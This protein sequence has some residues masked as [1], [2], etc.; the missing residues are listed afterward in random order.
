METLQGIIT[1]IIF[2]NNENGFTV[3]IMKCKDDSDK[4]GYKYHTCTGIIGN[5]YKGITVNLIGN[6]TTNNYGEQFKFE[7][8]ET[9]E[10]TFE[11]GIIGYLSCG[12]IDEVDYITAKKIYEKFKEDTIKILDR[13]PELLMEIKGIGKV[14]C[15]AIINSW[16]E[17]RINLKIHMLLQK[18]GISNNIIEKLK[19][20]CTN[21][22]NLKQL[23]INDNYDLISPYD[24][25]DSDN[26]LITFDIIERILQIVSPETFNEL[27]FSFKR[28]DCATY[29][30]LK[31]DNYNTGNICN[32]YDSVLKII[33]QKLNI[34]I[35]L[36][37]KRYQES[38]KDISDQSFLHTILETKIVSQVKPSNKGYF[39]C[40]NDYYNE[41][42]IAD[43]LYERMKFYKDHM[44]YNE[45]IVNKLVDK[46]E[47]ENNICYNESQRLAIVTAISNPVTIITGGPG[48]GKTT[49]IKA[50]KDILTCNNFQST[51]IKGQSVLLLAPTGKAVKR[52]RDATEHSA[53]TI[54]MVSLCQH[55]KFESAECIII[56]EASMIDNSLMALLC[57]RLYDATT[58]I[59]FVGDIHQLPSISPGNILGDFIESGR[60]PVITLNQI[61]RQEHGYI[62]TNA[63]KI[64]N[65]IMPEL[66][67]RD[68]KDFHYINTDRISNEISYQGI[69]EKL[70][71]EVLPNV[72][73]KEELQRELQ[74]L[75]PMK[76]GDNGIIAI[77]NFMQK[78]WEEDHKNLY[79]LYNDNKFTRF[80]ITK[81]DKV[82]N[83]GDR[84]I[85]CVNNYQDRIFNGE[86]GIISNIILKDEIR[87]KIKVL[88][89]HHKQYQKLKDSDYNI[90]INFHDNYY[91]GDKMITYEHLEDIQLAYALTIHKSQ[92]S[93]YKYVIMFLNAN[94]HVMLQR[95]LLYTGITRTKNILFLISDDNTIMKAIN[96]NKANKRLTLLKERLNEK[97]E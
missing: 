88:D 28:I 79:N 9:V 76:N 51:K 58:R 63:H 97:G 85:Y 20:K 38:Y 83:V 4:K 89:K 33:A 81:G 42:K 54:H 8:Y 95:N 57:N 56:D 67:N 65:G 69:L 36:L 3:F 23:I 60:F 73:D 29:W 39:Y 18:N 50:I 52:L 78:F 31:Q 91:S 70:L 25:N 37:D 27:E 45:T 66:Y 77:N 80:S 47:E 46:F 32:D 94:H 5:A 35:E 82:F 75:S 24:D 71:V 40:N 92:G 72:I 43:T 48:T 49:I 10:P 30:L 62:I 16:Q 96:N 6:F 7:S 34:N 11:E 86:V 26:K 21:K 61:Y 68:S 93:E 13:E 64:N 19:E 74:I 59:V 22:K 90:Y 12:I 14:K 44:Q 15:R 87:E 2:H 53:Y 55:E 17:H 1:K 41:I 84:I